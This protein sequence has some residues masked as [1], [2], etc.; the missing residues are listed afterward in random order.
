MKITILQKVPRNKV[1]KINKNG[2]VPKPNEEFTFKYLILYGFNIEIIRPSST[3]KMK[4]P[5]ILIMG[6]IWEV[7]TPISNKKNTIRNRF[8]EASDQADKIIFDLRKIKTNVDD[9]E[10]WLIGMFEKRGR[11]RR[12][13]IIEKSGRTIDVNKKG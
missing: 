1:G 10:K 13:I 2:V 3:E 5:D 12:M 7:K 9:V 8:R 11:V 4:N 6:T